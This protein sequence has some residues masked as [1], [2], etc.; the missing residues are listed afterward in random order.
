MKRFLVVSILMLFVV[1]VNAQQ[2]INWMPFDDAA[3]EK[4]ADEGKPIHLYLQANWCHWC[5]VMEDSTYHNSDVIEYLNENFVCVK[6]DQDA[7]PDLANKYRDYG[8]PALIFYTSEGKEMVKRP[9]YISP[10]YFQK[11]LKA[12]V[13]DPS[14]EVEYTKTKVQKSIQG[15][16]L[17]QII[18]ERLNS[19]LDLE[20]GGYDQAQKYVAFDTF[21]YCLENAADASFKSWL[22][23]SIEGS[24]G[25]N[26]PVWGG[27]YQYSTHYDWEH[28]HFEKLLT[29]QA[30]YIKMYTMFDAALGDA[31]SIKKAKHIAEYVQR[32]LTPAVGG[33]YNSQDADIIAGVH[34]ESYFD[35][36]D[37]ERLKEGIPRIDSNVFTSNSA[38]YAEALLYLWASTGD[39]KYLKK[40]EA[41]LKFLC[42]R[43]TKEGSVPHQASLDLLYAEDFLYLSEALITLRKVNS[44]PWIEKQTLSLLDFGLERFTN[45]EGLFNSF[46]GENGLSPLPLVGENIHLARIYNQA[47]LLFGDTRFTKAAK[48]IYSVLS[49]DKYYREVRNEPSYLLLGEEL[50][51]TYYEA[52]IVLKEGENLDELQ[53]KLIALG[54]SNIQINTYEL[55]N[56]P[57]AKEELFGGLGFSALFFCTDSYCSSP[58]SSLEELDEFLSRN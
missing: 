53:R 37:N 34:S 20:V 25:L 45:Q 4:A 35:K 6:A 12:I 11:L 56:L 2:K 47:G 26:D 28:L 54:K 43:V 39:K 8:W 55:D 32:F 51:K 57:K 46:I 40:G 3:F 21:E 19:S 48:I 38:R 41:T 27:V 33:F 30:R 7:R 13:K 1:I 58:I 24:F 36:S 50:S 49:N 23:K 9:G 10:T 17:K 44:E 15:S 18:Q 31:Q 16:S 52:S 14:P 42:S 29:I 22:N 5:H